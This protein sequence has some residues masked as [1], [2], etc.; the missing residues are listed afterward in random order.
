MARPRVRVDSEQKITSIVMGRTS[1]TRRELVQRCEL[2]ANLYRS[3][4]YK[5]EQGNYPFEGKS[6]RH[7]RESV[8]VTEVDD[9][10]I[11]ISVKA[12]AAEFVERGTG[13]GII[14]GDPYLYIPVKQGHARRK[15]GKARYLNVRGKDVKLA[16][17]KNTG[18]YFL[19]TTKVRAFNGYRLL[20]NSI[21]LAFRPVARTGRKRD[22]FGDLFG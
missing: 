10:R 9:N 6:Q 3:K 7:V 20:A 4:R 5:Y 14:E 1:R 22:P 15:R 8:S 12:P 19:V 17:N 18:Q 2:A 11:L 16:H 13:P 21:N